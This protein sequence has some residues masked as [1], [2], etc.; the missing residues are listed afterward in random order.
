M[1]G[2]EWQR[3]LGGFAEETKDATETVD[4]P[5]DS[6]QEDGPAE[7]TEVA[8]SDDASALLAAVKER[9]TNTGRSAKYHDFLTAI[10]SS[11][12]SEAALAI[13]AGHDDLITAFERC[14]AAP[15][16]KAAAP[17]PMD[18]DEPTTERRGPAARASQLVNLVFANKAGR[19]QERA[20]MLEYVKTRADQG[21]FPKRVFLLRGTAGAGGVEWAKESLGKEV[22]EGTSTVSQLAHVCSSDDF[23]PKN[24]VAS[25]IAN[26]ARVRLAMEAGLEPLYVTSPFMQLCEMNPYVSLADRLGYTVTV[27]AP[28]KIC[29]A[30]NDLQFLSSRK[31]E[32]L[33]KDVLKGM[34]SK[35]EKLPSSGD[36]R[37][38]IRAAETP[39]SAPIGSS[40]KVLAP[41]MLYMLE[42][43][44]LEGSE[45]TRS[46]PFK[47]KGWGV[48]GELNGTTHYFRDKVDGVCTYEDIDQWRSE[49]QDTWTFEGLT[50]LEDLRIQAF[51]LPEGDVPMNYVDAPK[52]PP[53]E[54]APPAPLTPPA[55]GF[56]EE[57]EVKV[58]PAAPAKP[59]SKVPMSRAERF[60]Q[61][62]MHFGVEEPTTNGGHAGEEEQAPAPPAKRFK[63]AGVAPR[64]PPPQPVNAD[65]YEPPKGMP[66]EQEEMSAAAFLAAVK[67]RLVDWGKVD[68]YHE[69]VVA[70]S[71]TV[72][73]KAAVRILRG[74]DD[75]LSVFRRKFAPKAD[76][77]QI[78]AEIDENDTS[79]PHAPPIPPPG[80]AVKQELGRPRS[81]V[82]QELGVKREFGKGVKTE[83]KS[84]DMP[85]PPSFAPNAH[86]G[87]VSIGDGDDDEEIMDNVSISLAV[88]KGR[89]ECIAQL[90]KCIFRK[91]RTNR[92]G[93][94]QRLDMVR[95]A[96]RRA[97][98]P[99]FPRE[100][101]IL[102]G[103]PGMGKTDY[104][105]RQLSDLVDI[106]PD[107]VEASR[108]TH[109]CAT[110]DFYETFAGEGPE[111]KF[112]VSK[113]DNQR[114]R[115]QARVRLAME[116]G[117]HPLFIDEPNMRL[118]EMKPYLAL[119]DRLGYVTTI[120]EPSDICDKCD[121]IAFLTSTND[122]VERNELG[123]AVSRE[124]LKAMLDSFEP[125][126]ADGEDAVRDSKQGDAPSVISVGGKPAKPAG[127]KRVVKA[128]KNQNHSF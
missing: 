17:E 36:P 93:V 2:L 27:V 78:K 69:F 21:A 48:N 26:E 70:L 41:V 49:N 6:G 59:A 3:L 90:A 12:G 85:R 124:M 20:K 83:V 109:A 99:R 86:K 44:M 47:G 72:D 107:E 46:T 45:L 120:V 74:H 87:V 125:L 25:S 112:D 127:Q 63:N 111:Y 94:R 60:K 101:F 104:A 73:A 22:V 14:F 97:S 28:E 75:L 114:L 56:Q 106:E 64:P 95:Y 118:W 121:D 89:D 84:E 43:L 110:D 66:T 1:S 96:T 117:I 52:T 115:N 7:K 103:P 37:P 71:G 88:K 62:A 40:P 38:L 10:S 42:K 53:Q 79:L 11:S 32:T 100:L 58:A 5:D 122:T 116:S 30:W 102:R 15:A 50:W 19:P 29:A 81:G 18:M 55:D 128:E 61:R 65:T 123:K 67:A 108:L 54:E 77:M 105:M 76:L 23:G 8:T 33:P 92:E 4:E 39:K 57:S 51:Q 119:A 91:E 16:R 126:P 113:L 31:E 24:S 98:K 9:L 35:F 13:L 80:S 82:K 34:I 68:Q